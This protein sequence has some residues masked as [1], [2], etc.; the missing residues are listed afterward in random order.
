[1]KYRVL[2]I[3][4]FICWG[5]PLL[6]ATIVL[7]AYWKTHAEFLLGDGLLLLVAGFILGLVGIG[8]VLLFLLLNMRSAEPERRKGRR[9]SIKAI[10]LILL[11][12]PLALIYVFVGGH[13]A[14][15][16]YL[17]I[18]NESP[19]RLNQVVI[20][21]AAHRQDLGEL[22]PGEKIETYHH[23]RQESG[24]KIQIVSK[25]QVKEAIIT[26]YATMLGQDDSRIIVSKDSEIII[27]K[28]KR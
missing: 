5:V 13:L 20:I 26:D 4:G 27:R 11:N 15:K 24:V 7:L 28:L 14:S 1:M 19:Y 17:E 16:I 18:V 25:N 10:T 22:E 9:I 8:C 6:A 23:P 12:I 2:L 3:S 21:S